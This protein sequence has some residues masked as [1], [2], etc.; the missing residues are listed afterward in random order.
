MLVRRLGAE[1]AERHARERRTARRTTCRAAGTWPSARGEVSSHGTNSSTD[2]RG[3]HGDDAEAAWTGSRAGSRSRAGN[4]TPARCAAAST[5]GLAGDVVVGVAEVVRQEEHEPGEQDQEGEHADRILR[6]RVRVHR[7]GIRRRLDVEPGGAVLA[8]EMQ[9]PEVQA[10]EAGDH[11]RQQVVQ[12]VEAVERDA[13]HR[14][15]APQPFDDRGAE[16]RNRCCRARRR[17]W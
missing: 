7:H 6:R 11:E 8:D 17:G 10:D 1:V 12:A 3:E 5:S 4:T 15:A 9:R 16:A 13:R 2:D 14:V